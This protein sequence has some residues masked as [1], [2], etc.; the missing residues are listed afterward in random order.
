MLIGLTLISG[1]GLGLAWLCS[2]L[3]QPL[4][5]LLTALILKTTFSLR[6]LD[7]AAREVQAALE[8]GDLSKPAACSPGILSV[9]TRLNFLPDRWPLRRSNQSP[10]MRL[11][12]W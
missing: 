10:K 6:G 3:P 8:Q 12:A 2:H 1:I 9:G 5:W 7:H 11:I 4:N